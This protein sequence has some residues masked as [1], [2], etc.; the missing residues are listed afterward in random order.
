MIISR[1][2]STI[3]LALACVILT[4]CS[5][6]VVEEVPI[7]ALPTLTQSPAP[8]HTPAIGEEG[9]GSS[10]AAV[11]Q[12]TATSTVTLTPVQQVTVPL[13]PSPTPG[14]AATSPPASVDAPPPVINYFVVTPE[15][16]VGGE[17][18]VLFWST[19][20][21]TEAAIYRLNADGTPGRAWTV[22]P[23]GSLT[24]TPTGSGDQVYLL[25]VSNGVTTVE[26]T[27][28]LS[29]ECEREWF[30]EPAPE[31]LCPADDPAASEAVVQD[32]ENGRM[33][34]LQLTEEII[35]LFDDFPTQAGQNNRAWITMP[36]LYT[37]GGLVEDPNIVPP[38]GLREPERGFGQVWRDTPGVRDRLG[39][40]T[41]AEETYNAFVQR[42]TLGEQTQLFFTNP[43]G[44]VITLVP[45]GRGWLVAGFVD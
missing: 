2:R 40:A 10:I 36:D 14:Q 44:E 29:Y 20:G 32:F 45:E 34:W 11:D 9:Q 4:A 41:S 24:L 25:V 26:T 17:P 6:W 38:E 3:I 22:D 35:V 5:S 7:A 18:I 19:E 21:V 15:E 16:P 31:E 12:A 13:L 33:V 43:A 39:W 28:T 1:L 23:E 27:L 37:E 8:S 42:A 30:F